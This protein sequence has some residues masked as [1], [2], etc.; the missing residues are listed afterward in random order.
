MNVV[1]N[2]QVSTL[3]ELV[4]ND[5]QYIVDGFNKDL[6]AWEARTK[7]QATFQWTFKT[8]TDGNAKMNLSIGSIVLPIVSTEPSSEEIDR[9]KE[10]LEG[11]APIKVG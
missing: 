1:T 10:I 7:S 5:L 3:Q 8:E 9:A 11:A 2:K 6:R 4:K